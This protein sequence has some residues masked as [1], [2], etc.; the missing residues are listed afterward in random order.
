[1]AKRNP[2]YTIAQEHPTIAKLSA[3]RQKVPQGYAELFQ[4]GVAPMHPIQFTMPYASDRITLQNKE[5][6]Q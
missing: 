2:N 6:T 1:M 3:V 4:K 5:E